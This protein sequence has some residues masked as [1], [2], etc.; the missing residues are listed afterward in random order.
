MT[1]DGVS[2]AHHIVFVCDHAFRRRRH[3]RHHLV[4]AA[5]AAGRPALPPP[6]ATAAERAGPAGRRQPR[7]SEH[8]GGRQPA[9]RVALQQAADEAARARRQRVRHRVLAA[10]DL[11]EERRRQP[12]VE[13]VAADE[14]RV[15][16]HA[17][18]PRVRRPARVVAPAARARPRRRA[19][20]AA[21]APG[22]ED[23]GA[24]VG[25]TAAP[26]RQA[27]VRRV[28]Q[29]ARVLQALQL[30]LRPVRGRGHRGQTHV[31][32]TGWDTNRSRGQTRR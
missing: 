29:H 26:V 6:P 2:R 4:A 1:D 21:P 16:H 18:A 7:V 24:D 5:A 20:A 17:D 31:Q 11:H 8:L 19:A 22:A 32:V 27:V 14:Q 10:P 3:F 28:A 12:V 25:G 15:R 13:G 23:L 9:L 30:Q